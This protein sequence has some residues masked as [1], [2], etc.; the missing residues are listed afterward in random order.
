MDR[1]APA[2]QCACLQS[3]VQSRL[4]PRRILSGMELQDTVASAE[5]LRVNLLI[6][7]ADGR[8]ALYSGALLRA[9]F[10]LATEITPEEVE[11]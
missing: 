3:S 10:D 11:D 8:Q 2:K 4:L 5:L 1:Q 9:V 7:F 6:E